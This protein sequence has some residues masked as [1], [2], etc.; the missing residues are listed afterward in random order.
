MNPKSIA[1]VI[2]EH[3]EH[4]LGIP[5]VVGISQGLLQGK[6]CLQIFVE[7]RPPPPQDRLPPILEGYPVVIK[8]TGP[9]R[10]V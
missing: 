7:D 9:F 10:A 6:P 2:Q 4:L 5:G 3:S 1:V 8:T